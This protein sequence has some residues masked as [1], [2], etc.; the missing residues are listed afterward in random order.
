LTMPFL[1]S[2]IGLA[3]AGLFVWWLAYRRYGKPHDVYVHA[4]IGEVPSGHPPALVKYLMTRHVGGQ[5]IV[6]TLIDLSQRGYLTIEETA[7]V[8]RGLFG[9]RVTRDYRFRR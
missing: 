7:R 1:W 9:E 2:S 4:S 8:S 5:A 3:T 6:A